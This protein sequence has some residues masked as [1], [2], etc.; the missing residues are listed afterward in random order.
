VRYFRA[1]RFAFDSPNWFAN[2]GA[3]TLGLFT[4]AFIPLIGQMVAMGYLFD[5]IEAM[6][7]QGNDRT[8]PD[9]RWD[10]FVPYLIRGAQTY[11]VQLLVSLP[12]I[13]LAAVAYIVA[14]VLIVLA[15]NDMVEPW[16]AILIVAG[17]FLVLLPIALLTSLV[18]VPLTLRAGLSQDLGLT[19]SWSFIKDYIG[20]MWWPTLLAEL[21]LLVSTLVVTLIGLSCLIVGI[22]AV[23]GLPFIARFHLEYQLYEMYLGRGG[24]PIPLKEEPPPELPPMV[25]PV[26]EGIQALPPYQP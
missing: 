20:R 9:F 24:T 11:L 14:F 26:Q 1:Y 7:R 18:Y 17:L 23:M 21:F 6:H 4:G 25:L 2:V 3:V 8:Y 19:W 15:A 12:L 13:L 5:V 22:Y 10:R 16:E